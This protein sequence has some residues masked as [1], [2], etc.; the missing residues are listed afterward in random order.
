VFFVNLIGHG[1]SYIHFMCFLNIWE[2]ISV[3]GSLMSS[4]DFINKELS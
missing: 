1:S 4:L 3:L 2:V